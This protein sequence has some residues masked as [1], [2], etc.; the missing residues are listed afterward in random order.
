VEITR[1]ER[2]G[3][4]TLLE[5]LA[6]VRDEERDRRELFAPERFPPGTLIVSPYL[7]AI[8]YRGLDREAAS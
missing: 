5:Y 1:K 6:V 4:D 7:R 2:L 8:D 3:A